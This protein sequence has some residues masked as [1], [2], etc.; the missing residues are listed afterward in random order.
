MAKEKLIE[1]PRY[2]YSRITWEERLELFT[3]MIL[4]TSI[5]PRALRGDKARRLRKLKSKVIVKK[6]YLTETE[7]E[8]ERKREL[9]SLPF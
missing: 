9:E 6:D 8:E 1:V 2:D 7:Y 4:E 3:L 5:C